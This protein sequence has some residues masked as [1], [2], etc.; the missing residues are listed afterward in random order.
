ME[1]AKFS[2]L[3]KIIQNERKMVHDSQF[4][5]NNLLRQ[6]E[7]LQA[8]LDRQKLRVQSLQNHID[9]IQ[10]YGQQVQG[11]HNSA[12][13]IPS[14]GIDNDELRKAH[15]TIDKLRRECETS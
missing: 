6:N 15:E 3:E 9:T 5:Q 13:L 10:K 12:P 7:E 1:K 11:A 2:D 4:N 14:Q 8:D